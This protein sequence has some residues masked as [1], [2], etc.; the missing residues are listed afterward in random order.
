VPREFLRSQLTARDPRQLSFLRSSNTLWALG[1]PARLG[2]HRRGIRI[3]RR[4]SHLILDAVS[5]K[6]YGLH[7][8]AGCAG[9]GFEE[10]LDCMTCRRW[11]R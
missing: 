9:A 4:G 5:F 10:P 2:T 11:L 1:E 3:T 8:L 6:V 7:G